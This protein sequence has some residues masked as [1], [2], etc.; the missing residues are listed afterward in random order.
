[1]FQQWLSFHEKHEK[2]KQRLETYFLKNG[3]SLNAYTVCHVLSDKKNQELRVSDLAP[4]L[5]LSSS[6]TSRLVA[7]L[8]AEIGY[9]RREVCEE[10]NRALYV[11]LTDKGQQFLAD[12]TA[13]V[14]DMLQEM[15]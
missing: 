7:K 3:S 13:D 10:D 2:L 11:V 6:A 14:E 15:F 4:Y 1:M 9:V 12:A 5:C 8:E